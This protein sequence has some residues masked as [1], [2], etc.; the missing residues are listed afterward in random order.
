MMVG[1]HQTA[2]HAS[3]LFPADPRAAMT[4]GV[5]ERADSALL[6]AE[7]DD[8]GAADLEGEVVPRPGDLRDQPRLE[9]VP[10]ENGATVELVRLWIHV[11]TPG[12]REPA[13][14][15]G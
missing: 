13:P 3:G 11:E 7:D 1:A 6:V 5:E 15:L 8:R 9:P 10:L 2:A 4:A 12:Q 14:P